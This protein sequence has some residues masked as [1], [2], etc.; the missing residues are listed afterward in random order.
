MTSNGELN[1]L[2]SKARAVGANVETQLDVD[3]LLEEGREVIAAV[4]IEGLK[5]VGPCW[6]SAIAAAERIRGLCDF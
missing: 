1:D 5:G 4:R 2:I 3:A 6:M